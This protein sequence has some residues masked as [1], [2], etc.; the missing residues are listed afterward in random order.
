MITTTINAAEFHITGRDAQ[1]L[2]QMCMIMKQSL[3]VDCKKPP[4][5]RIYS[6][7]VYNMMLEFVTMILLE[8]LQTPPNMKES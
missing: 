6:P 1:A 4:G 5:K 7:D 8:R 3:E 2:L